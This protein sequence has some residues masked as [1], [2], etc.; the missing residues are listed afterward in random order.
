MTDPVPPARPAPSD[1]PSR[2]GRG[3]RRKPALDS[4]IAASGLAFCGAFGMVLG[5]ALGQAPT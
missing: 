1:R 5:M 3:R 4:R 2:A